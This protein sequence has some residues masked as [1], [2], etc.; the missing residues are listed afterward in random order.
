M[1]S[2]RLQ[3]V[4]LTSLG[5]TCC[6]T[7]KWVQSNAPLAVPCVALN[8]VVTLKLHGKSADGMPPRNRMHWHSRD[9]T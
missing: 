4:V 9:R 8:Q 2:M 6:R 5:P 1:L 7:P 3:Q